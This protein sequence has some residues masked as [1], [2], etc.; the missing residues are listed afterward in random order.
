MISFELVF[1]QWVYKYH[2]WILILYE[3]I[4]YFKISFLVVY[5]VQKMLLSILNFRSL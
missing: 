3:I 2:N 1:E 5:L 4:Q